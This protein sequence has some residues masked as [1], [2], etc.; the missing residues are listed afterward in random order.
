[1][2]YRAP[3][4]VAFAVVLALAAAC[5]KSESP[6]PTPEATVT[7]SIASPAPSACAAAVATAPPTD[8]ATTAAKDAADAA[9]ASAEPKKPDAGRA[10]TTTSAAASASAGP[11]ECG[12][13]PLPDCPLQAWM[14][15]NANPPVM[16]KDLPGLASALDKIVG[17]APPGYTNWASI[18]KDG[19]A[20]ARAGDL[21]AAKASCRTC[22]DQYKQKY[23]AEIR[24][25]KL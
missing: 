13:K 7:P 6:A 24:A 1:M 22:H 15:A 19:A 21:D 20:A 18:A 9:R 4:V 14:K 2:P 3:P 25:R 11:P 12:A 10:S 23:K 5:T 16:T 17:F 8:T